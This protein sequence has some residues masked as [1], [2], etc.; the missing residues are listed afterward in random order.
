L[1]P[2]LQYGC[3]LSYDFLATIL[4][5]AISLLLLNTHFYFPIS[6]L[7]V[8]HLSLIYFKI[9]VGKPEGMRPLGRLRHRWEDGIRWIFKRLTGVGCGVDSIGSE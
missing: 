9:L 7:L 1:A 8:S 2:V 6:S 5:V 4:D 3:G